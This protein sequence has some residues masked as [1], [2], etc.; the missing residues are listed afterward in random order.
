MSELNLIAEDRRRFT[1]SSGSM[2]VHLIESN[3]GNPLVLLARDGRKIIGWCAWFNE[4]YRWSN[5][6][7]FYVHENYRRQG[8]ATMLAKKAHALGKLQVVQGDPWDARSRQFFDN[9]NR[10]IAA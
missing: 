9:V 4:H 10:K 5:M 7:M 1:G 3:A 6:Y 2:F 8:I